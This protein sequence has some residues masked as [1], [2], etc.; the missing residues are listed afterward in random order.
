MVSSALNGTDYVMFPNR[1][2]MKFADLTQD[3]DVQFTKAF[4]SINE[5]P[6]I[7][8]MVLCVVYLFCLVITCLCVSFLNHT[9]ATASYGSTPGFLK[10][11]SEVCVR[12]CMFICFSFCTHVSKSLSCITSLQSLYYTC[13][14]VSPGSKVFSELKTRCADS[15]QTFKSSFPS[16]LFWHSTAENTEVGLSGSQ[17]LYWLYVVILKVDMTLAYMYVNGYELGALLEN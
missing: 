1:R 8:V 11:L 10:L 15:L 3:C 16:E 13:T 12:V 4:W 7:R 17:E 6:T 9:C 14:Q 5:H 2:G